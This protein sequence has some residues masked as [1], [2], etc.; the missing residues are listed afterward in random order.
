MCRIVLI[1][2]IVVVK[3]IGVSVWLSLVNVIVV[4]IKVVFNL[5]CFGGMCSV[6]NLSLV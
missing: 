2:N 3:G 1:V 6:G 4:L 5:L